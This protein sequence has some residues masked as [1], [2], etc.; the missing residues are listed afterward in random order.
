MG[1]KL[2]QEFES[3]WIKDP[4]S[5]NTIWTKT[6]PQEMYIHLC[7]HGFNNMFEDEIKIEPIKYV[8]DNTKF[9][10]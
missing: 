6:I 5:S 10:K 2:K 1:L 4:F 9:N 8:K 3:V 7:K